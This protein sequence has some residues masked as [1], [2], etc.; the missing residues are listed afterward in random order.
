MMCH[1]PIIPLLSLAITSIVFGLIH[2]TVLPNAPGGTLV[3]CVAF[4]IATAFA[5]WHHAVNACV[6]YELGPD[7]DA[8]SSVQNLNLSPKKNK[9]LK[10]KVQTWFQKFKLWLRNLVRR[11]DNTNDAEHKNMPKTQLRHGGKFFLDNDLPQDKARSSQTGLSHPF[12]AQSGCSIK[13]KSLFQ[14]KNEDKAQLSHLFTR[15]G[16]NAVSED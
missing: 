4:T 6:E 10:S 13:S 16:S 3:G 1:Q 9:T 8:L 12:K 2:L 11:H 14:T 15:Q 7:E 5:Y